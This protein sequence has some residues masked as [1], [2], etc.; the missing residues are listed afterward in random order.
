MRNILVAVDLTNNS[1]NAFN[2]AIQLAQISG[3]KLHVLHC[4][5]SQHAD[6]NPDETAALHAALVTRIEKIIQDEAK[7]VELDSE[8][9]IEYRRIRIYE[10]IHR[11]A[12]SVRADL[13]VVGRSKS[14]EGFPRFVLLRTGRIVVNAYCPVLV[15]VRPVSREYLHVALEV[16]LSVYVENIIPLVLDFGKQVE[17]KILH[18]HP[19][20]PPHGLLQRFLRGLRERRLRQYGAQAVRLLQARG[21]P[22]SQVS[23]E[24]TSTGNTETLLAQLK[25][26]DVD[27][28]VVTDLY[29][30]LQ[31]P[32]TGDGLRSALRAVTC[33][34]LCV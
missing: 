4:A 28:V 20:D 27:V 25:D 10:A 19:A 26:K 18:R 23:F 12:R 11:H 29:R 14:S 7:S 32:D 30:K 1:Q 2:R 34:V 8:V 9:R 5:P 6:D 24:T 21:L 15:V 3:A 17:M 33:D 22:D 31:H 16:D 13:V